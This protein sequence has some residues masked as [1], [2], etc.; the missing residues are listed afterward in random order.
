MA[1]EQPPELRQNLLRKK[2]SRRALIGGVAMLGAGGAAAAVAA[3]VARDDGGAPAATAPS[4]LPT[5]SLT[6]SSTVAAATGPEPIGDPWRRAAHLLRRAGFGGTPAE[7]E[8]FAGLSPQEAAD[9]LVDYEATS[10]ADLDGRVAAANFNLKYP[11][12]TQQGQGPVAIDMQRW[13]LTRMSYTARPLEERMTFLWHGVL[14]SQLSK[15]GGQRGKFMVIQNELYRSMAM[16]RYD[17]LLKAAG[18]DPAMMVF[19]DTIESTAEAPNENYAREMM[20]LFSMGEGN[21]TEDDV[22]EAARAFTGWRLSAPERVDIPD[23]ISEAERRTLLNQAFGDYEPE[24]LVRPRLHDSGE[25]TFLGRTGPWDG[26]DIADIVMGQPATGRFI[27]TRLFSELAYRE[28]SDEVVDALVEVWDDSG[29]SVREVVRAI[30]ASDE[31]NSEQAYRAIVRSPV[32]FVVGA[33]RGL[34]F[35]TDFRGIDRIGGGMGQVLFEPPSV[36]GWPGGPSWLSSANFF[37]RVN[38]LDAFLFP[39]GRPIEVPVL[40]G[41]PTAEAMVDEALRRLVDDNV[42]DET[43][44]SLYAHATAISSARERA[45]TV[46]YLVLASPEFQLL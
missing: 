28:P 34:E 20:E 40:S 25:K 19:L 15:I 7:I 41:I 10:N 42:S 26:D 1:T 9:R 12:R 35:E 3:V 46:A 29:H 6:P 2:A 38:F 22:R 5:S 32:Q 4:A 36:G 16:G 8:E 14:T 24:F 43:R 21:Y 39:Q 11:G 30:L 13:W 17:G 44:E 27:T 18:K 31:F 23:G 45:A 33:V 37:G